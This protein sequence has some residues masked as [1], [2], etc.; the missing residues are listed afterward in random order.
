MPIIPKSRVRGKGQSA[1]KQKAQ[2]LRQRIDASIDTLAKAVDEVRASDAFRQYLATQARFHKYSW[3][4]CLLIASQRPD[5]TRVAGY[6]TW[7]GLKRQV[8]KGE[9]GIMI[10]APCPY[11]REI[12]KSDGS[13]E[14]REGMFFRAVHVFDV[15]QTDGPDLPTVDVPTVDAAADDLL[16]RLTR[17]ADLRG[18]AVSFGALSGGTFGVSKQGKVDI[19]NSHPTGQQAKTP[20]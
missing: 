16:A 7:Q 12:E 17:V 2:E 19:D 18:I 3:G 14:E 20:P 10:F 9:R 4:N 1:G 5:A 6:R 11:R 8:R 15:G 13:T